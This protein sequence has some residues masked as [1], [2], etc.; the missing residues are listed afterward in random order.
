MPASKTGV[1]RNPVHGTSTGYANYR[2]RCDE[3][4]AWN[5]RQARKRRAMKPDKWRAYALAYY[6]AHPHLRRGQTLKR[7]K[8]TPESYAS[9]LAAQDG[10]CAVCGTPPTENAPLQID[11]DHSCCSQQNKS[12][13]CCVRGL[14]C[15]RCNTG[16]AL[17][18][19]NQDRLQ[20]AIIYLKESTMKNMNKK[21]EYTPEEIRNVAD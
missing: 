21:R 15:K 1:W 18:S 11:H 6:Q 16:I 5:A 17:F 4:R 9:L 3:C 12:C 20:R 13:G 19:E 7:Y 8:L 2:C 14:L 10:V